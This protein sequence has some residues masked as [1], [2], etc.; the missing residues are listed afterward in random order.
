M[1]ELSQYE[2]IVLTEQLNIKTKNWFG[3]RKKTAP[4]VLFLQYFFE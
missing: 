2:R 4:D 3:M 1:L